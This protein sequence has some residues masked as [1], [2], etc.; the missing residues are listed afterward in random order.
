MISQV[1]LLLI[2][3]KYLSSTNFQNV[4]ELDTLYKEKNKNKRKKKG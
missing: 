4:P 3:M 1:L 2:I